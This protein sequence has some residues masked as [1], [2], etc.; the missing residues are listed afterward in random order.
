MGDL[1]DSKLVKA[2]SP[3]H[4]RAT[5]FQRKMRGGSQSSLLQVEDGKYY[6]VKML[7]NPQGSSVL[8]NETLGSEIMRLIGL[9]TPVWNPIAIS[10]QFIEDNPG[11]WFESAGSGLQRPSEGLHFGSQ[12][13]MP[14]P[15]E[16]LFEILPRSWFARIRN[17]GSFLGALLF[18]LWANQSDVRQAVFLQEIEN[19]SILATFIDHGALFG[20][21]DA[22]ISPKRIRA[23]YLDPE[24]YQ[25]IDV[26]S[27]LSKWTQRIA[28]LDEST[29][30]ILIDR[31]DIPTQWYTP[32]VIKR[33][34]SR[35]AER[36]GL[37]REY[38]DL[39]RAT[40]KSRSVDK[41]TE[42]PNER[43]GEV[44]LRG[45]Q[46]CTN[47]YRKILRAVHSVG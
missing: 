10:D 40:I 12:L 2:G 38:A 21:H 45:A 3:G 14:T 33:I 11:M 25:N 30:A 47:G 26:D 19:R 36:R 28:T 16:N 46:L 43:N 8:F 35:L 42:S 4:L 17:R 13:V 44:Q 41:L 18:D 23:M 6:I 1:M 22:R 31:A 15:N 29:L 32:E 9:E 5:K 7:G 34:V 24:I 20:H 37:L 39:I 27:T